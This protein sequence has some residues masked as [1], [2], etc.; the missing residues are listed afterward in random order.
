M[1]LAAFADALEA[2]GEAAG[3]WSPLRAAGPKAARPESRF[4]QTRPGSR[5]ASP[6]S[7]PGAHSAN[8]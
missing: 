2:I 5:R 3:D 8:R 6:G 7:S 4:Y 1:Q